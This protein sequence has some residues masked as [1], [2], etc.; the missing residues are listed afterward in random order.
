MKEIITKTNT[1]YDGK[2]L[3][4]RVDDVI[5]NGHDTIRE[6][7]EKKSRAVGVVPVFEDGRVVMVQQHRLAVDE[8]LLE[9]PAGL[10][11]EGEDPL[12]C[13]K[14]ELAEET[15]YRAKKWTKLTEFYTSAGFCD[16][17]VY[18]YLAQDLTP[19]ETHL[20]DTE[21]ID[22]LEYQLDDLCAMIKT[23]EVH[24]GKTVAGLALA[25]M[26]LEGSF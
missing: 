5:A 22:V 3:K 11:D 7:V 10:I 19:G 8:E 23:G 14:R 15:G 12:E 6:I 17:F 9:I 25:K 18:L 1:I 24:D 21:S 20:D 13:A 16:E 4:L 2:I 26:V